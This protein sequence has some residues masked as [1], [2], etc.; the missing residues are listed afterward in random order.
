MRDL[1]SDYSELKRTRSHSS[2]MTTGSRLSRGHAACSDAISGQEPS[3][4]SAKRRTSSISSVSPTS[5]GLGD[6]EEAATTRVPSLRGLRP[7][8]QRYPSCS[9]RSRRSPGAIRPPSS[10]LQKTPSTMRLSPKAPLA[11]LA[12]RSLN[13]WILSKLIRLTSRSHGPPLAKI[14]FTAHL[15]NR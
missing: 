6:R 5:K 3:S 10:T 9:T 2:A 11:T 4:E 15:G 7:V 13:S 14:R 12:P 1:Y 8:A